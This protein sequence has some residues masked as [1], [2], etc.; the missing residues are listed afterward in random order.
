MV[1]MR[2]LITGATGLVG[3]ELSST[4]VNLGHDVYSAHHKT[5]P[6][7]G[8]PI[9]LDINDARTVENCFKKINPDAIIHL[10]ALTDVDKCETER[11]LALQINCKAVE[12]I[13]REACKYGSHLVHVSTDYV[14]DGEK[15]MYTEADKPNPLNWYGESKLRG[16]EAVQSYASSW[17]IAR[18]STPYGLHPNK[19]SFPVLVVEKLSSGLEMQVLE[20]QYTSPTYV[21]NLAKMLIEIAEHKSQGIIHVSGSSRVSRLELAKLLANKLDLN[22]SM[23][24]PIKMQD[25]NW[26][27]KRPR[28]SSL[29]VTK[30]MSALKAKPESFEQSLQSFCNEL[31]TLLKSK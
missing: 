1:K 19:K 14:F 2:M 12:T 26:K 23:L 24:I 18:T 6:E 4:A 27:A 11:E 9:K 13:A 29:N 22:R 8:K 3:R 20:D 16:E 28:D 17:C 7:F 10:A 15:G 30:A 25:I 21:S 5:K 31:R